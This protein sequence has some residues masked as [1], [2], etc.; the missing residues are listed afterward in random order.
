MNDPDFAKVVSEM[1]CGLTV[2]WTKATLIV[3][4]SKLQ[5]C[6]MCTVFPKKPPSWRCHLSSNSAFAKLRTGS[7]VRARQH[8]QFAGNQNLGGDFL[9]FASFKIRTG[10]NCVFTRPSGRR[11]KHVQPICVCPLVSIRNNL[12]ANRLLVFSRIASLPGRF[13]LHDGE[14]RDA[15]SRKKA[16]DSSNQL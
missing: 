2:G 9:V 3:K 14:R 12:A 5:L 7:S 10:V 16:F 4:Q 13:L 8:C 6:E 15:G 11:E 1:Q